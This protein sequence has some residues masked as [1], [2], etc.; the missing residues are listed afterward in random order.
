MHR[1]LNIFSRQRLFKDHANEAVVANAMGLHPKTEG[2]LPWELYYPNYLELNYT[3]M[4]R[5]K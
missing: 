5:K 4:S 3:L 1:G 2:N